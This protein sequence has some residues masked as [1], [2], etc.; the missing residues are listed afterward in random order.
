MLSTS[1]KGHPIHPILVVLPLG[2]WTFALVCDIA[3]LLGGG[4]GW[5]TT[6]LYATGGGVVG[7][8][9]AAIPGLIDLLAITDAKVRRVAIWH[10]V[11]N[12]LAVAIFAAVFWL[13]WQDPASRAAMLLTLLGVLTIG[14]SGWLGGELVYRHGMGVQQ[15]GSSES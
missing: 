3:T 8:L 15:R 11:L 12:L 1:F 2:L 4:Q 7:A 9:L 6:A 5:Q 13:R 14:G 10:L